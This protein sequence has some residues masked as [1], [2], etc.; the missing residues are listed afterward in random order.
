MAVISNRHPIPGRMKGWRDR[1]EYRALVAAAFVICLVGLSAAALYQAI[2]GGGGQR[3]GS[4]VAEARSAAFAV[5]G[6]AFIA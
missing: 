4:L 3:R 5:V 6:Y 1:L 2:R